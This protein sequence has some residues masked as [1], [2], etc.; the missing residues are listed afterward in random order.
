MAFFAAARVSSAALGFLQH[1]GPQARP[2]R[3]RALLRCVAMRA[4]RLGASR[5]SPDLMQRLPWRMLQGT[6]NMC[7]MLKRRMLTS[8][9]PLRFRNVETQCQALAEA[10]VSG[11]IVPSSDGVEQLP[12][13]LYMAQTAWV[14][15]SIVET[16]SLWCDNEPPRS[17]STTTQE[18]GVIG[19]AAF[20]AWCK[21]LGR[22]TT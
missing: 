19:K 11:S 14:A 18:N 21:A 5:A 7:L 4:T 16:K 1:C 13:G 2:L 20:E 6:H 17:L 9:A 3:G 10:V 12:N 22:K 15:K 8:L